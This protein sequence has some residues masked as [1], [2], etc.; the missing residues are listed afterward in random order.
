MGWVFQFP[1]LGFRMGLLFSLPAALSRAL[2]LFCMCIWVCMC[3]VDP[4]TMDTMFGRGVVILKR[5]AKHRSEK[6]FA[7]VYFAVVVVVVGGGGGGGGGGGTK[8]SWN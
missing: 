2:R 8:P 3:K 4:Q 5:S 6:K 1:F 7:V